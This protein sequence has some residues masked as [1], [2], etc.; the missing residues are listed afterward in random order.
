MEKSYNSEVARNNKLVAICHT[1]EIA[2]IAVAYVGEYIKGLRSLGYVL[3]IALVGFIPP[4]SEWI[5]YSQKKDSA[6][7]KHFVGIGFALFYVL[8]LFTTENTLTFVYAIPM[9][10][11]IT[12]FNDFRYATCINVGVIIVN[13]L[14]AVCFLFK[15]I[16]TKDNLAGL[17]IQVLVMILFSIYAML[18]TKTMSAV[19]DEKIQRIDI[20]SGKTKGLLKNM[21]HV[22]KGI[23]E[24]VEQIHNKV[25]ELEESMSVT[26][27]AMQQVSMGTTDTAESAQ[28]QLEMTE[29]I[30]NKVD[31]VKYGADEINR[32]VDATINAISE[33]NDKIN[34]LLK[35]NENSVATG[36]EVADKL[37]ELNS[38]MNEMNSVVEII[39]EI[40]TQTSL[41]ALNASIE[42]ARAGE[43]GRG[44]AVVASE[45]SSMA[46]GTQD[47]TV[48]IT[49]MIDSVSGAIEDVVS[50]T[51]K[52]VDEIRM[53]STTTNETAKSFKTIET[54][55]NNIVSNSK[56][57]EN[58]VVHLENA[59]HE[60]IDSVS[61]ISAI[62]EEVSAH[63]G[64]TFTISEKNGENVQDIVSIVNNLTELT[65]KLES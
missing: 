63:A 44:F 39:T 12:V 8:V 10:I 24:G 17:E 53:Q 65:K 25:S 19:N 38:I 36:R 57:L 7:I 26:K 41:L 2:I 55:T 30:K 21:I 61:T 60:I 3:L 11:T 35:Q 64:D 52:M 15:G 16:Y 9:L 58:I 14:Q 33:G 40:T 22:S 5:I 4:V 45:I 31:A 51:G 48:K 56:E 62:S 54:N 6:L 13:T 28:K 32:S 46:T 34:N 49:E 29:N 43:A 18:T 37:A 47:A 1:V 59:N 27:E 23:T 42:A 20:E 50:V